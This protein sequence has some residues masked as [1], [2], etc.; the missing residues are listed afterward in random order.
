MAET[1]Y[2]LLGGLRELFIDALKVN[3]DAWDS[4]HEANALIESWNKE[5]DGIQAAFDRYTIQ[6]PEEREEKPS[7]YINADEFY[8]YID[9]Y[10]KEFQYTTPMTIED[11]LECINLY[12][13]KHGVEL[14]EEAGFEQSM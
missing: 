1:D 3:P 13:I 8:N 10:R 5:I 7:V 4:N 9:F 2:G 12:K 14:K 6:V 11:F